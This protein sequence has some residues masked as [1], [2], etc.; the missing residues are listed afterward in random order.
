[1]ASRF[2]KLS[3]PELE[4]LIENCNFSKEETSILNMASAGD[5]EVQIAEKIS[6][7]ASGVTKKKRRILLKIIGFLEV[8]DG[9]TTIYV[10]G[11]RVTKE[12][13]KNYEIKI[14]Q[15]KKILSEKLTN[16]K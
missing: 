10:N 11:E 8:L 14:E 5:S 2:T 7:S 15:V 13:L 4:F 6:A 1:M 16:K 9:M 3:K 12:N